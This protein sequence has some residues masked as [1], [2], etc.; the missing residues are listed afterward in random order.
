MARTRLLVLTPYP[1]GL[2]PGQRF[3]IE[4]W[5]GVLAAQGID[6]TYIPFADHALMGILFKP[7]H[8]LAKVSG[9]VRGWVRQSRQLRRLERPD[10]A[11]VFRAAALAGPPLVE[12]SLKRRG[13]PFIL[14]FDDA[15]FRLHST[16]ANRWFSWL[17]FPGKTQTLC[18]LASHV[19]VG[20]A[21]LRDWALDHN[22]KVSIVP[23]SVDLAH[24]PMR[25]RQV[26]DVVTV[27]W[28]GSHTSQTYLEAEAPMLRR[29]LERN[30]S[31]RL[32]VH[33]DRPP[34]LPG[35]AHEWRAWSAATEAEEISAFDIGI[36]P[37]PD[38]LWSRGKCSMKALL[39]MA[40]GSAAVCSA[41]G[42]NLE[43]IQS[44]V[45]GLLAANED[46][47]VEALTR[48]VTERTLRER[49]GLAGRRT[50]EERFSRE[51]CATSF[52]A[53]VRSLVPTS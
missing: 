47:W 44:G 8:T 2:V 36:M 50:I 41:V 51:I 25:P 38:D 34:V 35:V 1:T 30:P 39:Y 19:T 40:A 7:G 5:E 18:R 32:R 49:L 45:N 37:M 16:S 11:L 12:R 52:A 21:Y 13:I 26:S 15:I 43:V 33:S 31:A 48:L 6:C 23:S 3:R 4:Q 17:K 22:P 42:H 29:F 53:V 10:A 20:N 27:G 14:D 28:T 46:E 24:Y 9:V